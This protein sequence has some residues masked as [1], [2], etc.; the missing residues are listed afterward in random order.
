MRGGTLKEVQEILGHTSMTMT[1]RYAHL[2]QE[3]KREAVNLLKGLT[4][5]TCHKMSQNTILS[6]H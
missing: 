1:T 5:K 4:G 3:K 6:V 2:S